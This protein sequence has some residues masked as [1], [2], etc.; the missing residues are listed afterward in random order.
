MD[1][2]ERAR[3]R[4]LFGAATQTPWRQDGS[5]ITVVGSTLGACGGETV[6][7]EC[8]L[9]DIVDV[10]EEDR[11]EQEDRNA[12]LIVGAVN[13]L[14]A[15][16]DAAERAE[17]AAEL[18]ESTIAALRDQLAEVERE[19]DALASGAEDVRLALLDVV[20]H[21]TADPCDGDEQLAA[22]VAALIA[23]ID[24]SADGLHDTIDLACKQRDSAIAE[25]ERLRAIIAGRTTPP[26][27]AEIEAHDGA[28]CGWWPL[29]DDGRPCAWPVVPA[30][31]EGE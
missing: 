8:V 25:L 9:P 29:S 26:T 24:D 23:A 21:I 13:A 30:A 12:A 4:A 18:A 5:E 11:E 15:M 19:R 31:K 22:P 17:R 6:V 27:D 14:P 10:A 2:A 3:L 28:G 16:L 1:A 20:R 7:A